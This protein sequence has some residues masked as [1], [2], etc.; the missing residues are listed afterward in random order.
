M[1]HCTT[2]KCRALCDRHNTCHSYSY[3]S[4]FSLPTKHELDLRTLHFSFWVLCVCQGASTS[5]TLQTPSVSRTEVGEFVF[6]SFATTAP[7]RCLPRTSLP[8]HRDDVLQLHPQ[9]QH[10]TEPNQD[11]RKLFCQRVSSSQ[12]QL[13]R[14]SAVIEN[15]FCCDEPEKTVERP[16]LPPA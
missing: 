16:G 1:L 9:L 10:C 8:L 11:S 5:T 14:L 13:P 2:N 12:Q 7:L 6:D 15:L 4:R 3:R